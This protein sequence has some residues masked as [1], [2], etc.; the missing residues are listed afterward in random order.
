MVK[1]L[2][3]GHG[4][5]GKDTVA[6]IVTEYTGLRFESS[7]LA[8]AEIAVWPHMPQYGSAEECYQDRRNRREEWR[9]LI[10]DYNTPDKS[11]LCRQILARCDGYV[12]MRC[13]LEYAASRPLFDHVLWVDARQRVEQHDPTMKI[14]LGPEMTVIDNNGP[15]RETRVLV[16]LWCERAGLC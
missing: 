15:L 6:K 3:L 12:G 8:A 9:Q 7:S 1:I 2:I 16:R 11:R 14:P 10:T 5:H 13:P 4:E